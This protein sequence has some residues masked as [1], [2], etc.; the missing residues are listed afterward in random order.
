MTNIKLLGIT[1]D[2]TLTWKTHIEMIIPKLSVASFVVRPIKS[3]VMLDTLKMV[4]HSYFHSIINNGIIFWG[5]SSYS[6]CIFKLQKGIIGIIVG[7]IIRDSCREV[8]ELWNILTLMSQYIFT[9]LLFVVNNNNQF[10]VNS[11]IR[12]INTRKNSDL[13]IFIFIFTFIYIP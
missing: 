11:E 4:Y 8:F 6:N 10:W 1:I 9:L 3:F 5:N 13:F 12:N 2:N 7:V